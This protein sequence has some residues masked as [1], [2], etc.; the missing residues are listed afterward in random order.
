MDRQLRVNSGDV[1]RTCRRLP[2]QR[3]PLDR[4][5]LA[6]TKRRVKTKYGIAP[7]EILSTHLPSC[8]P[9]PL[10]CGSSKI[11]SAGDLRGTV[12]NDLTGLDAG[13]LGRTM[14]VWLVGEQSEEHR[15]GFLAAGRVRQDRT[16]YWRRVATD[17]AGTFQ[18]LA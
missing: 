18:F 8:L 4:Q 12:G 1:D 16:S 3:W 2:D 11:P 15:K 14:E 6:L 17:W 10:R 9:D 5:P 7:N 13:R